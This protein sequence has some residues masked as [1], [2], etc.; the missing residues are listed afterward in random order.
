MS[1]ISEIVNTIKQL[2]E[3][4]L[5]MIQEEVRT[6][7]T[8]FIARIAILVLMGIFALFLLLFLSLSL[9]FYLS[10]VTRSPFSGFLYVAGIYF[11]IL[12]ILYFVRNSLQL[13][14]NLRSSLSRFV[15]LGEQKKKEE[16]E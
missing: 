4:R 8:S 6:R 3:V 7:I 5:E 9:A 11:I 10:E 1:N 16:H 13:Q 14:A 15:F 2:I 12:I